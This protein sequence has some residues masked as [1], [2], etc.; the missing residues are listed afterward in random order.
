[1]SKSYR[2]AL[3]TLA[4]MLA[5]GGAE[6][7]QAQTQG[8][9]EKRVDSPFTRSLYWFR[10]VAGA[11]IRETCAQQTGTVLR[12]VYNAQF[13]EQVRAYDI[14]IAPDGQG[15][16]KVRVWV[17]QGN[18]FEVTT[19]DPLAPWKPGKDTV[20]LNPSQSADLMARL[21]QSA[22]FGPP[23]KGRE[24]ISNDYW[25]TIASCRNGKWGFQAYDYPTDKFAKVKFSEFLFGLDAHPT[26]PAPPK[27]LP[28]AI[29]RGDST[30]RWQ[31][32]VGADGLR[33]Y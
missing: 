31:L 10:Y 17:N 12:I 33:D 27:D 2:K 11:D 6:A 21:D 8:R 3:A 25:W 14:R 5:L 20:P 1:M 32:A 26:K 9:F 29:F 22:G 4:T 23:P 16:M 18:V 13:R 19:D 30:Q 7:A 28:P 15:L 24:L